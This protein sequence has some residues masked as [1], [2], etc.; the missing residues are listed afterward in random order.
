MNHMK[1]MISSMSYNFE[2]CSSSVNTV[3]A[4]PS[5][6][7]LKPH[8][9]NIHLNNKHSGDLKIRMYLPCMAFSKIWWSDFENC[10]FWLFYGHKM[11]I[12]WRE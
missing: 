6:Y 1:N 4:E 11:A 9:R 10:A 7:I 8:Q 2:N 12:K 3:H 5:D